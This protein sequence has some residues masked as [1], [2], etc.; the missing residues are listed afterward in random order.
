MRKQARKEKRNNKGRDRLYERLF[1][2]LFQAILYI[3][4]ARLERPPQKPSDERKLD[5]ETEEPI[6]AADKW[7]EDRV[8]HDD[9]RKDRDVEVPLRDPLERLPECFCRNAKNGQTRDNREDQCDD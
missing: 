3:I 9:R 1:E 2:Q 4:L 5:G 6:F 8:H 7:E